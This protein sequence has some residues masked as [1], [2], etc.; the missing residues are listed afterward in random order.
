[1]SGTVKS[2][3]CE[4][5][6]GTEFR[7]Q[8]P[9]AAAGVAFGHHPRGGV[10]KRPRGPTKNGVCGRFRAIDASV[11]LATDYG[12]SA[13]ASARDRVAFGMW[14]ALITPQFTFLLTPQ[15]SIGGR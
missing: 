4:S 14:L 8:T 5:F 13:K 15:P 7:L 2:T 9:E 10:V 6:P 3:G 12:R 1:M 11:L